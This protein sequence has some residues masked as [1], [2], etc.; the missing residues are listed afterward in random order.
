[1]LWSI[2]A[3]DEEKM[4]IWAFEEGRGEKSKNPKFFHVFWN[5]SELGNITLPIFFPK[6]PP[7]GTHLRWKGQSSG[8]CQFFRNGSST[9]TLTLRPQPQSEAQNS[10]FFGKKFFFTYKSFK[11]NVPAFQNGIKLYGSSN[12]CRAVSINVKKCIFL[13]I[14]NLNI[15][16]F[17]MKQNFEFFVRF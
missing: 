14:Q 3:L 5:F 12:G 17:K 13:E 6:K 8:P 15:L 9:S 1:M 4:P 2:L 11:C 16:T 7:H 10:V